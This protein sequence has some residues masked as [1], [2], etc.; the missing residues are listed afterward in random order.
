[1]PCAGVLCNTMRHG[2]REATA[3]GRE[4]L[5]VPSDEHRAAD[6]VGMGGASTPSSLHHRHDVK[7]L[8]GAV[9]FGSAG[10]TSFDKF[11]IGLLEDYVYSPYGRWTVSIL[12][13]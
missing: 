1:M 8:L 5:V 4:A 12:R 10:F 2:T 11:A 13:V 7:S 3:R 9:D 6:V